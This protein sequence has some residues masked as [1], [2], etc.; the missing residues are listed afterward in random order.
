MSACEI[1]DWLALSGVLSRACSAD[2]FRR[3]APVAQRGFGGPPLRHGNDAPDAEDRA[4]R[5]DHAIERRAPDLVEVLADF[6]VDMSNQ[7]PF[8]LRIQRIALDE[9]FRQ[10]DHAH[11]EAASELDRSAGPARHFDAAA[12]DINHHGGFARPAGAI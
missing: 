5:A 6:A 4:R 1:P 12:P 7:L 8:V 10:S 9:P 2:L 3:D 11:L